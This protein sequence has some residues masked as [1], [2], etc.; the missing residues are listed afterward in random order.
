MSTANAAPGARV[1]LTVAK[2][3]KLAIGKSTKCMGTSFNLCGFW[4]TETIDVYEPATFS[5]DRGN[6]VSFYKYEDS[7]SSSSEYP[8][9]I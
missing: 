1:W 9:I 3:V 2:S 7:E 4:Q 5:D 6:A 8:S